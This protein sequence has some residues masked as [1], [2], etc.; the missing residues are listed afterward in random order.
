MMDRSDE[1]ILSVFNGLSP[2]D[3]P[4]GVYLVRPDGRF[5]VA[6]LPVRRL[7][8]LPEGELPGCSLIDFFKERNDYEQLLSEARKHAGNGYPMKQQLVRLRAGP[9]EVYAEASCKPVMDEDSGEVIAYYGCLIDRTGEVTGEMQKQQLVEKVGELTA[10][11]GRVLHA[12][13][14]TLNMV[15]LALDPAMEIFARELEQ[16]PDGIELLPEVETALLDRGAQQ[17]VA[18]IQHFFDST[19]EEMRKKALPALRWEYLHQVMD[20]LAH[21]RETVPVIEARPSFLRTL[22]KEVLSICGEIKPGNLPKESLRELQRSALLLNKAAVYVSVTRALVAVTMMDHSL[23]ALRDYVTS[24]LRDKEAWRYLPL[25]S[26]LDHAISSLSEFAESR[27]VEVQVRDHVPGLQIPLLEREVQR[28]FTN[29]LH[30]AIKYSWSR[31]QGKSPWVTVEIRATE[32]EVS[33]AFQ[34][35]GV[36][37]A[38]DEIETGI[39]F[40]LGYR[41]RLSKDRNRLGTGI[42]LTDALQTAHAHGGDVQVSSYPAA[43]KQIDESDPEYYKQPFITLVTMTLSR[44]PNRSGV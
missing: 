13:N 43:H 6:S 36:A 2:Q 35:W 29:L 41:G 12:N 9:V 4:I 17:L 20:D 27:R 5:L 7:L 32:R 40:N 33:V 8:N 24:D 37:I 15:R 30:N 39:L 18:S 38:K 23:Q 44:N 28:A 34:N 25:R 19:V 3:L 21:F 22:S 1:T 26:V 10:D 31:A 14:N 42:G 11:I 16:K